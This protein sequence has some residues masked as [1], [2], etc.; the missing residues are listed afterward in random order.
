MQ[1]YVVLFEGVLLI[2]YYYYL[3]VT[4]IVLH[5]GTNQGCAIYR[6]NTVA[7]YISD[8]TITIFII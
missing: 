3:I 7:M 1:W 8:K 4:Y 6:G 5:W 2:K